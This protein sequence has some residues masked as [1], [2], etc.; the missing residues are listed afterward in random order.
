MSGAA[1]VDPQDKVRVDVSKTY[2][3]AIEKT[4]AGEG[5]CGQTSCCGS[6]SAATANVE[7]I[8]YGIHEV[9]ELPADAVVSSFGCGNPL[10]FSGVKP[11]DT[12]LDL[13]SGAGLDLLIARKKVGETGR[14]IGVDMTDA[15][16]DR[17]R[18]NIAKLGYTNVEV[19]KGI[20]EQLP[21]ETGTVDWVISNCV[22][23][24]S[25]DKPR[26]FAE[27]ARVLK[28]G[29][30]MSVSD[31][32][33]KD[34]P[35][36]ARK[37]MSLYA[38][39]IGGAISEDAYFAGLEK[40]GLTN[41]RVMERLIYDREQIDAFITDMLPKFLGPAACVLQGFVKPILSRIG[42][43]IAGNIWSA[44]FTAAKPA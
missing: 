42:G 9:A 4:K 3:R 34:L 17:A 30:Q 11:G 36:W 23:N 44:K 33:A 2:A 43:R 14:V 20:I 41:V 32:V 35:W 38:S 19:R 29:G 22:I 24:L 12:V 15:M 40:A 6:S 25:P 1:T 13:G 27:I 16:I 39:C 31:I 21:V 10:A 7:A 26:V 37:S 5:C 8:G 28:P 18:A